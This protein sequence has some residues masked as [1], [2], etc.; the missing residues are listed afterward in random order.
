M[1]AYLVSA[2][3]PRPFD[4]DYT[5]KQRRPEDPKGMYIDAGI[6]GICTSASCS[7]RWIRVFCLEK[8]PQ[9]YQTKRLFSAL[10]SAFFTSIVQPDSQLVRVPSGGHFQVDILREQ[11]QAQNSTLQLAH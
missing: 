7:R 2:Q 11:Q 8:V 10:Q 1:A 6:K 3:Q 4:L 5:S 9:L